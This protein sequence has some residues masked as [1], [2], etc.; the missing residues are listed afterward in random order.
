L[1]RIYSKAIEDNSMKGPYNAVSPQHVTH[2]D[3]MHILAKVLNLPVLPVPI[4]GLILRTVLGEM[5]DIVLKGSRV[6]SDKIIRSGFRFQFGDL[7]EALYN[8]VR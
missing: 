7:E 3:F 4:P 8:I 6:T 5:S 2:K 1:C